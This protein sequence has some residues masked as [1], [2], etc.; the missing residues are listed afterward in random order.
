METVLLFS[1]LQVVI[2]TMKKN[3]SVS[4]KKQKYEFSFTAVTILREKINPNLIQSNPAKI[5]T[6]GVVS[7][8]TSK[9]RL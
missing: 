8:Q 9:P 2:C 7:R 5:S 4:N 6:D 1:D 3:H